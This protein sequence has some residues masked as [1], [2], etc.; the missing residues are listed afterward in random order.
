[1]KKTPHAI[2]RMAIIWTLHSFSSLISETD[3][4]AKS[5][6]KK[7]ER[8]DFWGTFLGPKLLL[9]SPTSTSSIPS[10]SQRLISH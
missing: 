1:M 8:V 3:L 4:P 6:K 9:P 5:R 7:T 2:P 10:H